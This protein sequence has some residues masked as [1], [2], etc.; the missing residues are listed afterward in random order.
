MLTRGAGQHSSADI[1]DKAP[2]VTVRRVSAVA[3]VEGTPVL[4][5]PD[6]LVGGVGGSE[7]LSEAN[8]DVAVFLFVGI[9][10]SVVGL[11]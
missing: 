3:W 1:L 7:L 6:S 5:A 11:I 9:C 10:A 4:R 8:S 2:F